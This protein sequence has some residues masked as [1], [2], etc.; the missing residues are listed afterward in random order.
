[1]SVSNKQ[2]TA[3]IIPS[4]GGDRITEATTGSAAKDLRATHD[5]VVL[6]GGRLL[7][8]VGLKTAIPEGYG[9]FITPRSGLANKYGITVL[10][11]PGLITQITEVS[12]EL[13]Y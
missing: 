8:K 6:A 5:G 1:M 2:D 13:F 4:Q 9:V 7:V 11:S 3:V 12:M 10:N